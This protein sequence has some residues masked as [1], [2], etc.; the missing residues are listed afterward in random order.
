MPLAEGTFLWST[1]TKS[2]LCVTLG[3]FD[4]V[5]TTWKDVGGATLDINWGNN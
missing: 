1:I 3:Y 5:S 2:L 4:I